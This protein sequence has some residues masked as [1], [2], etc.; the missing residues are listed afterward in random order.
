MN[1]ET[2]SKISKKFQDRRAE[3][4]KEIY[5]NIEKLSNLKT[6]KEAQVNMLSLRQ[7]LL[8]DNHTLFEHITILRKKYRDDRSIE[9]ENISKN[10]QIRYQAN[11]KNIVIEGRTSPTKEALEIFENQVSFFTESIKTIDNV[12]FGIKTRLD[13]EKTLGL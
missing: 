7:R 3:V 5:E 11:E 1:D 4:S 10:L 2:K 13:I 8:E 6:L 9:M 12:I